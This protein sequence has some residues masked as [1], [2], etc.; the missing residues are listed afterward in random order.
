MTN[1]SYVSAPEETEPMNDFGYQATSILMGHLMGNQEII[2]EEDA[3]FEA[4]EKSSVK[5][6]VVALVKKLFSLN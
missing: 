4:E 2:P 5:S 3:V 6:A 1:G